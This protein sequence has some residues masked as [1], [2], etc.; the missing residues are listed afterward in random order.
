RPLS[1]MLQ[2]GTFSTRTVV[3]SSAVIRYPAAL[4]PDQACLIG[5]CVATGIGS[6]QNTAR[7]DEGARVGVIGCGAVGLSVVQGARLSRA[8]E[9]HAIDVDEKRAEQALLFGATHT[10]RGEELE[11]VFDVVG[12]PE[13]LELGLELLGRGGTLVSIGLPFPGAVARIDLERFFDR[14]LR[15]LVSHGGDHLP[16]EDFPRYAALAL[17]GEIDLAGLVTKTIE[18]EDVE[19]A[20]R[21]MRAGLGIRSVV[22]GF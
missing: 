20:F 5:C 17:A 11:A 12:R 22:L 21:D 13:T 16:A 9:I 7:L 3:H 18:L 15:I 8:A 2:L 19:S 6:V 10:D 4:P 1:Q 14:R